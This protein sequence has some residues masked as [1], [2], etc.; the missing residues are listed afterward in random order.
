M[1]NQAKGGGSKN[2]LIALISI[3]FITLLLFSG[4]IKNDILYGWDDGEYLEDLSIQNLE[5]EK[6]FTSYYLG[7]YQPLAVLSLSLNYKAAGL[8]AP[9]YH[10][11]NIILHLLNVSLVFLLFIKFSK[12]LQIAAIIAFLFAIHPMHVEAVSWIATRSNSLYSLFFLASLFYYL[13]YLETKKYLD[14]TISFLFFIFSCF[15]KSMAI[16]L[17]LVLLLLDY[18]NNRQFDKNLFFE[19]IPFLLVSIIFG[20]V[21]I[22]AASDFG[23]IK[24]L[25]VDYHLID[26]FVLFIY[27]IVF[28]ILR[29]IAPNNLSAVYA[30]PEKFNGLLSWDYYASLAFF[31]LLVIIVLKSG[32]HKKQVI[33]GLLFFIITIFPVLPILW[34]RMLMLADR[35]TYIP[36]IGLF[37][38]LSHFY[39]IFRDSKNLK[40]RKYRLS[41]SIGLIIYALFLTV[42]TYQRI[43]IWSNAYKMISNVI[44]NNRSDVDVSIGYFFRGNIRDIARDYD[45]AISDFSKAIELNPDYTMAYNNRGI[46]KGTKGNFKEAWN[47]FNK[48]IELEPTYADAIYNRGNAY[49]YLEEPD[50]ACKDWEKA[51]RLGSKQANL[52]Y[53]KYC[54]PN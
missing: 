27:A 12:R 9:A 38:I 43:D 20:I 24:N 3:L 34:S 46:I 10:L 6:F 41:L 48:A 53:N 42:T 28:Y 44:E 54:R 18:Y 36:Y 51:S 19:K 22:N 49:F 37:F 15:S 52:I 21:T 45:G 5:V 2:N 39:T 13:I 35:Y 8:S 7:M 16:T 1:A 47:D 30:Y 26:R 31:G 32:K 11:T 23:H 33:F 4:S 14:L 25:E 17:P 29:A 40:I 50:N